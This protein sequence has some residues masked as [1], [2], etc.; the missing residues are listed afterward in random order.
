MAAQ[1]R[2]N[3]RENRRMN[4]P[5]VGGNGTVDV[6]EYV[7][8]LGVEGDR[9]LE[10]TKRLNEYALNIANDPRAVNVLIARGENINTE[11]F[12]TASNN[13]ASMA[14]NPISLVQANTN[15]P[16]QNTIVFVSQ[17]LA[18]LADWSVLMSTQMTSMESSVD[19]GE[20]RERTTPENINIPAQGRG[21]IRFTLAKESMVNFWVDANKAV[22]KKENKNPDITLSLS[23]NNLDKTYV[24]RKPGVGES[25]SYVLPAGTYTLTISD[26]TDY[27]STTIFEQSYISTLTADIELGMNVKPYTTQRIEGRISIP[28]SGKTFDVS[29]GVAEFERLPNGDWERVKSNETKSLNPSL[30]VWVPIHGWNNSERTAAMEELARSFTTMGYQTVMIDWKEAAD[31]IALGGADWTPA[32]G[33]WVANQLK[34]AGFKGE[35][36]NLA[37][38][39]WGSYV[40]YFVGQS[41]GEVNSIVAMDSAA[42]GIITKRLKSTDID[43]KEV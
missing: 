5:N 13:I 30:P 32:V 34:A 17:E 16:R 4:D 21:E 9:R 19:L 24:S 36:I 41:F 26:D 28:E 15:T 11:R 18:S 8:S 43:F 39:S 33:T 23:G 14:N 1:S 10:R 35:N 42:D 2:I 12:M 7:A 25:I 20:I 27:E 38:Y 22:I 40:A 29:M 3:N 31:S 37:G 6:S